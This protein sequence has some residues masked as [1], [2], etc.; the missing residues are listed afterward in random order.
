MG[1]KIPYLGIF[2]LQFN[3]NYYQVFNQRTRIRKTIKFHP[4][5]KKINLGP[6]MLYLGLWLECW[7]T[8]VIFLINGLQIVQLQSFVQK[9]EFLNLEPKNALFKCFGQRFWKIIVILE[10][11]TLDF[12]LLQSFVQ[13]IKIL[14]FETKNVR[15]LYF[16]TW[17][18]KYCC[19]IWNQRPQICLAAKFGGKIK[20]L[21]FGAKNAWFGYFWTGSWKLYCHI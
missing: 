15:F 8:I 9:L 2:G 21:K 3:K 20:I 4:K 16:G 12:V 6:K 7:K 13:K 14:K 17:I 19:H 5:R 1:P 18:W 10:I 11:S